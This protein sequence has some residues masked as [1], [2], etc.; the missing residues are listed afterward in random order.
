MHVGS[1]PRAI[2]GGN[3]AGASQVTSAPALSTPADSPTMSNDGGNPA[4]EVCERL[5]GRLEVVRIMSAGTSS[6]DKCWWLGN[7]G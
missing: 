3:R 1:N 4:L 7:R 2:L 6:A 5:E